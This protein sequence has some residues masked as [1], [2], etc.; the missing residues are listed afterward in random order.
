MSS[1]TNGK[2][3]LIDEGLKHFVRSKQLCNP[4]CKEVLQVFLYNH[5]ECKKTILST[6]NLI[7]SKLIDTFS[8]SASQIMDKCN[9]RRKVNS[10]YL[11]YCLLK[12]ARY[13]NYQNSI[14]RRQNFIDKLHSPFNVHLTERRCIKKK[15]SEKSNEPTQLIHQSPDEDQYYEPPSKINCKK[16]GKKISSKTI[17][18]A[19]MTSTLDRTKLSSRSASYVLTNFA[20]RITTDTSKLPL[21]RETIRRSRLTQQKNIHENLKLNIQKEKFFTVHWDGKILYNNQKRE[22]LERLAI[23]VTG[24]DNRDQLLAVPQLQSATGEAQAE[25]IFK[26]LNDW[27]LVNSVTATCS[28]TTANNTGM[29]SSILF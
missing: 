27:N 17:F 28:D 25:A 20:S 2:Y 22:R 6:A 7:A 3:W 12:K 26:T 5:I 4:T 8:E 15:K 19:C 21:S 10:L 1:N 9:L 11:E 23:V 13:S 29:F 18:D 24:A 16:P 14:K